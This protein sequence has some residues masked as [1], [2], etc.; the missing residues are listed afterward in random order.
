MDY[1]KL[2]LVKKTEMTM[3]IQKDILKLQQ[4]AN[5]SK[6]NFNREKCKVLLLDSKLNCTSTEWEEGS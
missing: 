3:V 4:W 2:G 5:S 6:I 1:T